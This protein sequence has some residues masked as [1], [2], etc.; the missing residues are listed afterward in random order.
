MGRDPFHHPRVLRAPSNLALN[1]ARE[2]AATASLGNLGQGLTTLLS[3]TFLC[4]HP[5][6]SVNVPRITVS[7]VHSLHNAEIPFALF[8][9][10]GDTR[11]TE[12][13]HHKVHDLPHR[14]NRE[15]SAFFHTLIFSSLNS[16]SPVFATRIM[17]SSGTQD[18]KGK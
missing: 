13:V 1:P 12:Y 10:R 6:R 4:L 16:F 7:K 8:F 15:V 9:Y 11:N 2:G 3:Q 5:P 14:F 18:K 17:L